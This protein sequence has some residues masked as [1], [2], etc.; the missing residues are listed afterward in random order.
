MF[1][2]LATVGDNLVIGTDKGNV[3]VMSRCI[4]DDEG[5]RESPLLNMA[6]IEPYF[7]LYR[8]PLVPRMR[9]DA[10]IISDVQIETEDVKLRLW[11]YDSFSIKAGYS[12]ETHTWLVAFPL[13]VVS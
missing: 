1:K 2:I 3:G 6:E 10:P 7:D 8:V 13:A 4:M 9:S 5:L 12:Y 11:R